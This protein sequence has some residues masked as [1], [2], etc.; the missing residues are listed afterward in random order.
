M[1]PFNKRFNK[2][3]DLGFDAFVYQVPV[4][5]KKFPVVSFYRDLWFFH[6]FDFEVF[7]DNLKC[8]LGSKSSISSSRWDHGCGNLFQQRLTS[9]KPVIG[10]FERGG[11]RTVIFRDSEQN[12]L[13]FTELILNSLNWGGDS[14]G[15]DIFVE[16]W[17]IGDISPL[18]FNIF[19]IDSLAGSQ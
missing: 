8:F 13:A 17:K 1:N 16:K 19:V 5:G 9:W 11:D 3:C 2:S 15:F 6:E 4:L 14:F 12:S 10:V 18:E 7:S